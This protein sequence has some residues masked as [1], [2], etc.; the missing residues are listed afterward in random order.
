MPGAGPV[1]VPGRCRHNGPWFQ[2]PTKEAGCKPQ[3][4][5][6]SLRSTFIV[7]VFLNSGSERTDEIG[8]SAA[9]TSF[10]GDKILAH[11][12]VKTTL[13]EWVRSKYSRKAPGADPGFSRFLCGEDATSKAASIAVKDPYRVLRNQRISIS[14]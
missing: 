13:V 1:E 6:S 3:L 10:A 8:V 2:P 9:F 11:G 7:D 14:A 12:P 5:R 4:C